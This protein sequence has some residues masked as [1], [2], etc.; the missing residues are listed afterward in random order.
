MC[1]SFGSSL[2]GPALQWYTNLANNFISSF[3]QVTDTFVEQFASN[4]KL[5]RLSSNLYCIQQRHTKSL[6]D[7]VECFNR[8]KASIPLCNQETA[9][10]AFC[11]GILPN[12][13]LCEDLTKFNC[14]IME[15][16]L[17]HAWKK[18]R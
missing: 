18:I 3:A 13:E 10:D 12:G 2:Q 17:A 16:A 11:K 7:Y 4:K 8:D 9:A 5:E 14:T 15:E 6:R 1:K